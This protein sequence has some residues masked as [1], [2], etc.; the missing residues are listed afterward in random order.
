MRANV[1]QFFE[2]RS[3]KKVI[4]SFFCAA[5]L[6][7]CGTLGAPILKSINSGNGIFQGPNERRIYGEKFLLG[8]VF[9]DVESAIIKSLPVPP[10]DKIKENF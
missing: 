1:S 7:G 3:V 9:S 4:A 5:L 6:A 2:E 8:Y 10:V